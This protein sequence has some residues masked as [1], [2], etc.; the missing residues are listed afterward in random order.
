MGRQQENLGYGR[1]YRSGSS[2]FRRKVEMAAIPD[3]STTFRVRLPVPQSLFRVYMRL[4]F[5]SELVV[6]NVSPPDCDEKLSDVYEMPIIW[7]NISLVS[8]L[9]GI[10]LVKVGRSGSAIQYLP[11]AVIAVRQSPET[12]PA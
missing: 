10:V 7:R 12:S 2:T 9:F 6:V 11:N 3:V 4:T 1:I 5:Q 8:V